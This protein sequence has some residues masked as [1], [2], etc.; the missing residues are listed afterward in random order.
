[1]NNEQLKHLRACASQ[2]QKNKNWTTIIK[3]LSNVSPNEIVNLCDELLAL[4][5]GNLKSPS[6]V[7][8][9]AALEA[10]IGCEVDFP[11]NDKITDGYAIRYPGFTYNPDL[12]GPKDGLIWSAQEQFVYK[13]RQ[14]GEL[15]VGKFIKK[16]EEQ[17]A[18]PTWDLSVK[19]GTREDYQSTITFRYTRSSAASQMSIF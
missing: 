9:K 15:E 16:M 6:Y 12:P 11:T 3:F 1:M 2:V 7:P 10:A 18:I 19:V 8:S 4:R 5:A 13:L 17:A 14:A